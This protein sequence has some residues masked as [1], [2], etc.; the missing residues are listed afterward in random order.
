MYQGSVFGMICAHPIS[1]DETPRPV[2]PT[3]TA[4]GARSAVTRP[5][6]RRWR[7]RR[8]VG[9]TVYT[10]SS[11]PRSSSLP[12]PHGVPHPPSH[13]ASA[14]SRSSRSSRS[15]GGSPAAL[16]A[17]ALLA[18]PA[19]TRACLSSLTSRATTA[20][21]STSGNLLRTRSSTTRTRRRSSCVTGVRRFGSTFPR[22]SR[23]S[24][25]YATSHSS[26]TSPSTYSPAVG[27]RRENRQTPI[28]LFCLG[29]FCWSGLSGLSGFLL[30]LALCRRFPAIRSTPPPSPP[31]S[32]LHSSPH[33]VNTRPS[34]CF[35]AL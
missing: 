23:Y 5:R 6:V 31:H 35:P 1:V 8:R 25:R 11:S 28:C 16:G 20:S 22:C 3:L 34:T 21:S 12:A 9:R 33:V 27:E 7:C 4:V 15:I 19:P 2:Y 32:P 10:L 14:S 18:S 17:A 29:A 30:R 13:P 26:A 24:R